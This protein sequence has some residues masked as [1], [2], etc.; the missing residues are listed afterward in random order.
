M[1]MG[2]A[3]WAFSAGFFHGLLSG[4]LRSS[5]GGAVHSTF[6]ADAV[7]G[8]VASV[9]AVRACDGGARFLVVH[10]ENVICYTLFLSVL[11]LLLE[12]EVAQN[13]GSS[14]WQGLGGLGKAG[15]DSVADTTKIRATEG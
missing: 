15:N 4:S 3:F 10:N 1:V 8:G 6:F 11:D 13:V 2:S 12:I 14:V 7:R 9:L 5:N